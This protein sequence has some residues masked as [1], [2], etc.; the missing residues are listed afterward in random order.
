MALQRCS[1]LS[2][3]LNRVEGQIGSTFSLG[4]GSE[5]EPLVA[6]ALLENNWNEKLVEAVQD[7]GWDGTRFIQPVDVR[8]L[9][10]R[11]KALMFENIEE[12]GRGSYSTVYKALDKLGGE[13]I[14]LKKLKLD[15][16]EEGVPGMAIR[17]VSLLKEL[18]HENIV[19]YGALT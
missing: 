5:L 10:C 6:A 14:T 12:L 18:Q 17:E 9:F 15:A 11:L 3:L 13:I 16:E 1:A 2:I 4:N 8:G 7:S 19:K